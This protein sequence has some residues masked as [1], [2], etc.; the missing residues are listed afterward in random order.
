MADFRL[1]LGEDLPDQGLE[2][3][4]QRRIGD[5]ALVLVELAGREQA[6]RRRQGFVKFT[7][8]RRFA[9]AGIAGHH[10]KFGGAI[11][12]DLIERGDQRFDLGFAPI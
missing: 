1:A 5:V 2:G 10:H 8:H 9:D 12:H 6:A 7:H 3:L 11:G 4:R